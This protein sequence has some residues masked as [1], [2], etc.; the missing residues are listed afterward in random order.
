M[1]EPPAEHSADKHPPAEHSAP[2]SPTDTR[3]GAPDSFETWQ[4][5]DPK[6]VLASTVL[7]IAPM[8]PIV[9]V[10]ALSRDNSSRAL[11]TA[12]VWLII[13]L[14]TTLGSWLH[15][16]FTR[17]R[18]TEERF[19]LRQGNISRSFS[20]IPRERIRS[21]DLTAPVAHRLL[22]ISVVKIG[23]GRQSGSDGD[24]KLDALPTARAEQLRE[25]LLRP[26]SRPTTGDADD[27]PATGRSG[28][29]EQGP[30]S[31]L[32]RMR[33]SWYLYSTLTASLLLVTWAALGS[34]MSTL[35]D[36]FRA[37]WASDTATD[38]LSDKAVSVWT[39]VPVWLAIASALV[40]VLLGGLL[41]ALALSVEMWWG[42]RLTGAGDTTL[43]TRRGL[44]TT[45]AVSLER[46]RLRG[47]EL[48]EPL[49]LRLA[50]GSRLTAVATGLGEGT[51]GGRSDNKALLPPAPRGVAARIGAR[52]LERSD[53]LDDGNPLRAHPRAALRRRLTRALL[54]VAAVSGAFAVAAASTEVI[55]WWS[56]L[57]PLVA[58]FPAAVFARDAYRNL[59]HGHRDEYLVTRYGTGVKRTVLLQREGIIGWRISQSPVQ[60]LTGLLT[61][62]A[63]TAAGDGCY[64]VRDAGAEQGLAFAER[65]VPGLLEPFLEKNSESPGEPAT[66]TIESTH[67]SG[68]ETAP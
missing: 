3:P 59:G 7:V 44:L 18:I 29:V 53:S 38:W 30:G 47:V 66:P 16:Y 42:F 13:V 2:E 46:R 39:H 35:G 36:V 48:A 57:V 50:G 28:T 9:G 45:R 19:E 25:L 26:R 55:P 54:P 8:F 33:P 6:A 65:C 61:V 5:L 68:N 27:R 49:L 34:A 1:S 17:F 63:T 52:V 32:A 62:G 31:E 60:R 37:L 21:V 40:A 15:W 4:R 51:A 64:Y 22:G 24:L 41:G 67:E 20:S 23:T 58:G 43:R 10:M 56:W 14:L 12:G 11:G